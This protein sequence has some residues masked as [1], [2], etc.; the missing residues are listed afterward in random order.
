MANTQYL[1]FNVYTLYR[2]QDLVRALGTYS[3]KDGDMSRLMCNYGDAS[4]LI[5]S[6]P[7]CTHGEIH[8]LERKLKR[9]VKVVIKCFV[10]LLIKSFALISIASFCSPLRNV[11]S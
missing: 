2:R 11:Y 8:R 10:T 5:C 4:R 6:F 3:E 7:V 1:Y 9:N